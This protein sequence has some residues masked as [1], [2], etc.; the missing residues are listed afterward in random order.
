MLY[1]LY[2]SV[3]LYAVQECDISKTLAPYTIAIAN[4]GAALGQLGPNYLAAKSRPLNFYLP[5]IFLTGVLAFCWMA[6]HSP[7]GLIVVVFSMI[8]GFLG[9]FGVPVRTHLRLGY[10]QILLTLLVRGLE[11]LWCLRVL[12]C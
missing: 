3:E 4:A 1:V 2:F 6:V 9:V 12:I 11:W 10:L 5:C 8:Y 7:G